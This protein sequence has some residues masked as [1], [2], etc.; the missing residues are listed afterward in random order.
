MQC[1]LP[2]SPSSLLI[3]DITIIITIYT[4]QNSWQTRNTF[5]C[6]LNSPVGTETSI[7][8]GIVF[9][10]ILVTNPKYFL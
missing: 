10:V 7:F 3:V 5:L 2:L 8:L 1:F 4:T 9:V 6:A